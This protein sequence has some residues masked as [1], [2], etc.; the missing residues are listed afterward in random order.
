MPTKKDRIPASPLAP[1]MVQMLYDAPPAVDFGRLTAKVEEYCGRTD[2]AHRPAADATIA[3]YFM[4]DAMMQYKEGRLPSQ[5]CLC[6]IDKPPDA[7]RLDMALQQTWDWAE[8]REAAASTKHM[9]LAND[10]MAAALEPKVRNK[11]F[12]GFIRAI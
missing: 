2:P 7:S 6:R 4:L 11:Q 1:L 10:L 3:H 8:A 12:R 9:L 5:L